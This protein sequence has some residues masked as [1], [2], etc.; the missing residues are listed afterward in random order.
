MSFVIMLDA[1][2]A[3]F[4][5]HWPVRAGDDTIEA[6]RAVTQFAGNPALIPRAGR[7]MVRVEDKSLTNSQTGAVASGAIYRST[8]QP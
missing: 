4:P 3:V 2:L 7:K 1:E 5:A 6:V 8:P